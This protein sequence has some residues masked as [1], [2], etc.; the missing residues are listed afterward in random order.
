MK[1]DR[2]QPVDYDPRHTSI[3]NPAGFLQQNGRELVAGVEGS[4]IPYRNSPLV[5]A[6]FSAFHHDHLWLF[7]HREI[8]PD[9]LRSAAGKL[10]FL[11]ADSLM[12][13]GPEAAGLW[14]SEEYVHSFG[15]TTGNVHLNL[16][17]L[18]KLWW[19]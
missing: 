1:E 7:D 6:S 15:V 16:N 19:T 2:C 11:L 4:H 3:P 9:L 12:G 8:R 18:D 14:K 5:A 10:T 13:L 17:L